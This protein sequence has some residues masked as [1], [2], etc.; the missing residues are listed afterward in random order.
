MAKKREL[1]KAI[2]LMST[3]LLIELLGAEQSGTGVQKQDV[4]NIA[5]SILL[6]RNDF[7]N[8]LSHIDK[9]QVKAFFKQMEEDLNTSTNEIIDQICHLI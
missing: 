9:R 3:D 7:V 8:R 1:K 6:M 4:E 5:Q 2:N